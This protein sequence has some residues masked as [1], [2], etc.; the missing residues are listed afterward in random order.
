[1]KFITEFEVPEYFEN[2]KRMP[3]VP[4]KRHACE[5][6]IGNMIADS[7]GWQNPVNHNLDHHRLEIEAFP[8]DKW[9]EFKQKLYKHLYSLA[10]S[11]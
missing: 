7:F 10:Y 6:A 8:M 4:Q 2:N 11:A 1:M 5:V 9:I 3:Y